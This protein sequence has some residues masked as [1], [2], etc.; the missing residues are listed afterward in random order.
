V[1][2]LHYISEK[3]SF[4]GKIRKYIVSFKHFKENTMG[5][6][7]AFWELV[8]TDILYDAVAL[9]SIVFYIWARI[10]LNELIP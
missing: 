3:H 4:S 5:Y 8:T 9:G 7:Q 1:L 2:Y 6:L 10:M